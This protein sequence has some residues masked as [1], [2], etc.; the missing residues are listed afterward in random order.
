[1]AGMTAVLLNP[2][3]TA[4]EL[5]AAFARLDVD[6][7]LVADEIQTPGRGLA[8]RAEIPLVTMYP[9]AS[10]PVGLFSLA[11]PSG[12]PI[13]DTGDPGP[14][15]PAI[16]SSTTGTTS[17]PKWVMHR[18][19][20]TAAGVVFQNRAYGVTPS[21]R[22]LVL[23]PVHIMAGLNCVL[24][25]LA[26]GA[27]AFCPD[28]F[29]LRALPGWMA[30]CEVTWTVANGPT[31]E[32]LVA[33]ARDQ[34]R[35]A[36]WGSLRAIYHGG[37]A[38]PESLVQELEAVFQVDVLYCY[39]MTE[40]PTIATVGPGMRQAKAGAVGVSCGPEVAIMDTDGRILGPGQVGEVVLGGPTVLEGYLDDPEVNRDAFRDGWFRSG[41]MG[42]LDE[43]G[44]IYLT[45]R[46]KEIVNRGGD[47]VSPMEV[48]AVL[49]RHP[50]V[51][52]VVVFALPH[53]TLGEDLGAA[54]VLREGETFDEQAL[55]A[56]LLEHLT[57]YKVPAASSTSKASRPTAARSN[58][59]GWPRAWDLCRK[60]SSR[61]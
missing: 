25:P 2:E 46:I 27:S 22:A 16:I 30:E 32:A 59:L 38:V 5:E 28:P 50:A 7:L 45:G 60:G 41:D 53:R 39:G 18:Q 19:R 47:K 42:R 23:F 13:H 15:N 29:D 56:H 55:R 44:Y 14:E 6:A 43:D 40:V 37:M 11:G 21:D 4:A 49:E 31:L 34:P 20:Q 61:A 36:G 26:G 10:G 17:R 35:A 58:A 57:P 33:S 54:V 12:R 1:M 9:E 3:S 52:D 24:G 8:D 51:K 48:E